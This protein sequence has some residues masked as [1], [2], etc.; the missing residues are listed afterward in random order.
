MI[1]QTGQGVAPGDVYVR[2]TIDGGV[3]TLEDNKKAVLES[4][5]NTQ[6]AELVTRA[7]LGAGAIEVDGTYL[8]ADDFAK[9]TNRNDPTLRLY[10]IR[11]SLRK[12]KQRGGLVILLT[13]LGA[14]ITAVVAVFFL[15]SSHAQPSPSALVGTA[16]TVLAWVGQPADKLDVD[17]SSAQVVVVRQQLDT[18]S[19]EAQWCLLA[20]EGQK[21]PSVTIPGVTCAPATVPWWRSSF[22]GSLITG[23]IAVLTALIGIVALRSKYGFQRSP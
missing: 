23:G 7:N 8:N 9:F 1:H 12:V 18:R 17:V 5:D 21:T 10:T 16:Q 6:R 13:A 11:D 2:W 3:Q 20:T 4:H 22:T 15:W 14:L 19:R